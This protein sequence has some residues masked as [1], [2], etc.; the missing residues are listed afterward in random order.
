MGLNIVLVDCFA[1]QTQQQMKQE[2]V[3]SVDKTS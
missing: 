3:G 2:E 1:K